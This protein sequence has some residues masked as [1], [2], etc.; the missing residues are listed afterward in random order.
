MALP[1]DSCCWIVVRERCVCSSAESAKNPTDQPAGPSTARSCGGNE[2]H[3]REVR[4]PSGGQPGTKFGCDAGCLGG[5]KSE[6][7]PRGSGQLCRDGGTHGR[8]RG[9]CDGR[10]RLVE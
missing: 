10:G 1:V 8:R 7:C 3:V 2:R 6:H 9:H 5:G 4:N